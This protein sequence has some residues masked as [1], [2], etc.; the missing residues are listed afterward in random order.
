MDFGLDSFS[1]GCSYQHCVIRR[2]GDP[3]RC[4]IIR[5]PHQSLRFFLTNICFS[6]GKTEKK[7]FGTNKKFVLSF[8]T[9][10][11][12]KNSWKKIVKEI[13]EKMR[14]IYIIKAGV[15]LSVCQHSNVQM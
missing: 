1:G 7:L 8:S 2:T 10:Q 3:S 15:C 14:C 9:A 4:E 6:T 5:C 12:E 13:G 11:T